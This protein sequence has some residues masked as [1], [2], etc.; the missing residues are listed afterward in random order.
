ML[1]NY[2]F[3]AMLGVDSRRIKLKIK[4]MMEFKF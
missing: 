2:G 1:K 3:G 4:M